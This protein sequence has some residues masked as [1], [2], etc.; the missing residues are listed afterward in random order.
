MSDISLSAGIRN[1]LLQLQLLQSAADKN[2]QRLASGKKVS[3]VLDDPVN[4]YRSK[5]SYDL[6]D[7]MQGYKDGIDQGISTLKAMENGLD[8]YKD[9][10]QQVQGL[11]EQAK[12]ASAA[13][14][15]TLQLNAGALLGAARDLLYDTSVSGTNLIYQTTRGVQLNGTDTDDGL[16]YP[17]Q[18]RLYPGQYQSYTQAVWVNTTSNTGAMVLDNAGYDNVEIANTGVVR[19]RSTGTSTIFVGTTK[20]NDG[21]WHRIVTVHD[22]QNGQ[23]RIYVD[24][25]LDATSTDNNALGVTLLNPGSGGGSHS[26]GGTGSNGISYAATALA[27]D[28]V[29]FWAGLP[30]ATAAGPR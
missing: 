13:D 12:N 16:D 27:V 18:R 17:G 25:K 23:D 1:S 15:L 28:D 26:I 4:F 30:S 14:K 24:G 20:V 7:S 22:A 6:A 10:L 2:N 9:I 19:M 8:K 5:G 3:Q 29:Q 21:N 11:A